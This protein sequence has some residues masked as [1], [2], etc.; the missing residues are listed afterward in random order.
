MYNYEKS[1]KAVLLSLA[2]LAPY[3][4]T[5]DAV[6]GQENMW[7]NANRA[8]YSTLIYND[9]DDNG[10][11][12]PAPQRTQFAPVPTGLT[13]AAQSDKDDI[14]SI[15]GM[16]QNS[17]GQHGAETSGRAILAREKQ[18]DNA[19]F[20][21]ADNMSRAIALTGRILLELIPSYYDTKRLV[22]V[23]QK[24]DTRKMV[25]VNDPATQV[26]Q[27]GSVQ[28][29]LN[30]DLS[31]GEYAVTVE[32][33]PSYATARE[34]TRESLMALVQSDPAIMQI[35][36]D[37]IVGA[38][39]FPD[40]EELGER[41]KLMLPPPIQQHLAAK[42]QGEDPKV[43]ALNAQL[44]QQ[45]QQMQQL[46]QQA[47][48]A[49]QQAQQ[50]VRQAQ[51]ERDGL[52]AQMASQQ[53][54]QA[55]KAQELQTK[56]ER[57]A[58]ELALKERAQSL[59]ENEFEATTVLDL[60]K[61]QQ[62]QT[63]PVGPEALALEPVADALVEDKPDPQ[64]ELMMQMAQHLAGMTDQ[65]SGL[66]KAVAAPRRNVPQRGPDG[67]ITHVDSVPIQQGQ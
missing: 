42:G 58:R 5:R 37:I 16:Y 60:I 47:Q 4:A 38:M 34:Q 49:V 14:K 40:A 66:A 55:L 41:L 6:A 25:V 26:M 11:P 32:A 48:Q 51:A 45:G 31:V 52:K 29:I 7:K 23:I 28:A 39:D 57:D 54:D 22:T 61:L 56:A 10:N 19:T 46:Q 20:H 9:R 59:A 3:I 2:P 27:D 1:M 21:F 33:G 50:A 24:D 30:N 35:A 65:I 13:E 15:I 12:I 18:G 62:T 17:L 63:E 36:G 64:A 44:A 43:A 8:R 53:G 67:L